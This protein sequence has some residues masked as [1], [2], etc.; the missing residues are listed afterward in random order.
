MLAKKYFDPVSSKLNESE[1][2]RRF[3][4]LMNM[5][6]PEHVTKLRMNVEPQEDNWTYVFSLNDDILYQSG[7]LS[8]GYG[9]DLALFQK[10]VLLQNILAAMRSSEQSVTESNLKSL[11]SIAKTAEL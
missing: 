1:R 10:H 7:A 6:A 3:D 4:D 11:H 2:L 5:L 9:Q 8:I